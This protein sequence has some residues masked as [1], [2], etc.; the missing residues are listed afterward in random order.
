MQMTP[1]PFWLMMVSTAIAV[2]P[3]WRSP[4]I[5][6]RWP[7]PM[8]IMASMA[9]RPILDADDPGALLVDDGVDRD[10]RLAGLAVADDQLALAAADGDHGVDGLEAG[11]RCR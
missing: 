3:V 8:G 6:S 9:L 4:M 10:R 1:V 5:S 2:L 11:L 7:R